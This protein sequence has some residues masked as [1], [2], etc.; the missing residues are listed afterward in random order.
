LF[1][2]VSGFF[3]SV[4]LAGS[5]ASVGSGAVSFFAG[6]SS[7]TTLGSGFAGDFS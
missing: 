7:T 1:T 6:L 5:G 4:V 2:L 3:S